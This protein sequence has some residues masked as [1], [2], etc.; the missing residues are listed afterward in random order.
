MTVVLL[1]VVPV[2]SGLT[3][4]TYRSPLE[5]KRLL[6][7]L[8]AVLVA[9]ILLMVF[10]NF[11]M[12]SAYKSLGAIADDIYDGDMYWAARDAI[13]ERQ[14]DLR[15]FGQ[16]VG[17]FAYMIVLYWLPAILKKNEK[18]NTDE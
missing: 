6:K 1:V 9:A 16:V 8:Y 13:Y 12:W 4:L 2:L 10:W 14:I 18:E 15:W 17:I 5:G 11:A 3:I 7:I